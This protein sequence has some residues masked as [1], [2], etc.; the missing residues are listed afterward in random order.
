VLGDRLYGNDA[1]RTRSQRLHLHAYR[2]DL[3]HPVTGEPL[4]LKAP[5][6]ED[7]PPVPPGTIPD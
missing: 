1:A 2:L 3:P 7:W 4:S 5:V 6:P